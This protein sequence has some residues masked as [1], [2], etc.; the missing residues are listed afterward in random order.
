MDEV[1]LYGLPEK[2]NP[3]PLVLLNLTSVLK[4]K[5]VTKP[6]AQCVIEISDSGSS[7][8]SDEEYKLEKREDG[9]DSATETDIESDDPCSS[10]EAD[11][12]SSVHA[13]SNSSSDS[14][15]EY[16]PYRSLYNELSS[17]EDETR[18]ANLRKRPLRMT[19][20][21]DSDGNYTRS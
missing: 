16:R 19:L 7:S 17:P 18:S 3:R 5:H 1:F 13:V 12:S 4:R 2:K 9:T 20:K 10:Y 8:D 21:L 6:A 11:R 15:D 14:E